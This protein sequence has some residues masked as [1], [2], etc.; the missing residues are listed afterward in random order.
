MKNKQ[1]NI[2]LF[3][4]FN[5]VRVYC[6]LSVFLGYESHV[7]QSF[8]HWN[9]LHHQ[10]LSSMKQANFNHHKTGRYQVLI[11][12][13]KSQL[14]MV[15]SDTRTKRGG[16]SINFEGVSQQSIFIPNNDVTISST[17]STNNSLIDFLIYSQEDSNPCILGVPSKSIIPRTKNVEGDET[18]KTY[19]CYQPPIQWFGI[20]LKPVFTNQIQ[21][22]RL[23][24]RLRRKGTS[25]DDINS[26]VHEEISYKIL[27]SIVGART[28]LQNESSASNV[29]A[30]VMKRS[31][32]SG[33]NA[34][35]ITPKYTEVGDQVDGWTVSSDFKLQLMVP[36]PSLLPL[37]PGFNSIGSRIVSSTV[38][39]RVDQSLNDISDAYNSW[40]R[41]KS[42]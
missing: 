26:V 12:K 22:R 40:A 37:P 39:K 6:A 42:N 21:R 29:V 14:Q 27:V 23:T 16:K 32:F 30:G 18:V 20:D 5:C 36:L 19:D 31:M 38:K 2:I 3:L 35:T 9:F 41:N 28:D 1:K 25:D 15:L 8:N 34:L 24:R 4:S 33:S 13:E 7:V 11:N 17:A 10:R